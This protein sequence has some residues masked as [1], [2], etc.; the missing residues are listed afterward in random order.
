MKITTRSR[1][2]KVA[3]ELIQKRGVN[4][5]SFQ[6]ISDVV[7][8]RKASLYHHFSSKE[9]LI[10]ELIGHCQETYGSS[11]NDIVLGESLAFEKLIALAKIFEEGLVE[12]KT[13]LVGMLIAER[14]SLQD[15]PKEA[16]QAAVE[17]TLKIIE[18]V[19]KQ[20]KK[21]RSVDCRSDPASSALMFFSF[22]Q[23][24]QLSARTLGGKKIFRK[25]ANAMLASLK[26]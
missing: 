18:K 12:G 17:N 15:K 10:C 16:V 22:L 4:D 9:E 19:F 3:E 7:G 8:I 6:E 14:E 1:I 25:S 13:C 20:G 11:Y 23:G 5:V 26:A 24:A 21:D 2:L